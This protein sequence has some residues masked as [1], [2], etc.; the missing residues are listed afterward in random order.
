MHERHAIAVGARIQ[1]GDREKK[2][3]KDGQE[4]AAHPVLPPSELI[5]LEA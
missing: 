2:D 1:R 3:R 5:G 4:Y